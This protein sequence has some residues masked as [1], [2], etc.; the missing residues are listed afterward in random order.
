MSKQICV[1]ISLTAKEIALI[2]Q[3]A[4]QMQCSRTDLV[5]QALRQFLEKSCREAQ[6][7]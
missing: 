7:S 6:R 3:L 4:K 1:A 5:R 2:K